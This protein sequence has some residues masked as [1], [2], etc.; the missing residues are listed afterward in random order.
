MIKKRIIVNSDPAIGVRFRDIDDRLAILFL[1][2]SPEIKLEGITINFGNVGAQ[3]GTKVAHDQFNLC[4]SD[5]PGYTGAA[6]KK[7]LG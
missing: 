5:V 7:Q 1:L 4:R 3:K 2:A 6:S